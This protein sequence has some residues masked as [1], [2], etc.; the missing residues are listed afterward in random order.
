MV[1][2]CTVMKPAGMVLVLG[3]F[4]MSTTLPPDPYAVNR[5]QSRYR[6]INGVA[7]PEAIVDYGAGI[8][9][10][11]ESVIATVAVG[12]IPGLGSHSVASAVADPVLSSR[13]SASAG[14]QSDRLRP[15]VDCY[16]LGRP[17]RKY[18]AGTR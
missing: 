14:P 16:C 12:D 17:A 7:A 9:Q 10:N 8:L 3:D 1:A 4:D 13:P 11:T 18:N 15:G 2:K 5:G 6:A